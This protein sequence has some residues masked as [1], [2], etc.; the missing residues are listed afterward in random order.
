MTGGDLTWHDPQDAWQLLHDCSNT[1]LSN[2]A[3]S[4]AEN[5]GITPW[6]CPAEV[7]WRDFA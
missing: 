7:K 2:K 5:L 3:T 6:R 1:F 4:L